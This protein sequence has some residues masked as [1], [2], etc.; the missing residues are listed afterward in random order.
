VDQRAPQASSKQVLFRIDSPI[1]PSADGGA[2]VDS[3]GSVIGIATIPPQASAHDGF[4][5]PMTLARSIAWDLITSG[6]APYPSLGF[7]GARTEG[8][9]DRDAGVR[10]L[11]VNTGPAKTAGLQKDDII[12]AADGTATTSMA[13]LIV[14]ARERGAGNSVALQVL[15]NEKPISLT[16]TLSSG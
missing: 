1:D 15:R 14:H 2:V 11:S 13:A 3:T 4:A 8:T 7:D 10:V 5:I 12:V 9:R 16:L 6:S